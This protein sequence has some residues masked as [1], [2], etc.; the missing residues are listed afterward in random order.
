M[1]LK[2]QE[3][4]SRDVANLTDLELTETRPT[5]LEGRQSIPTRQN[6]RVE[7]GFSPAS[8]GLFERLRG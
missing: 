5:S 3:T 2:M 1:A 6:A 4:L 8:S 7:A